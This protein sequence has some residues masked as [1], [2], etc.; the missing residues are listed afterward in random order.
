M[1]DQAEISLSA[2]NDVEDENCGP[3]LVQKLE[4]FIGFIFNLFVLMIIF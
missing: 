1:A 4:V 2:A 3:I